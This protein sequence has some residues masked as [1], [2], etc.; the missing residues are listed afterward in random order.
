MAPERI[1]SNVN[2]YFFLMRSARA[3]WT[4]N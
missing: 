4:K 3:L 2:Y 1:Y